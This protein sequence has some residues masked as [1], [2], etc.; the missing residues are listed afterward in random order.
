MSALHWP[1]IRGR[2]RAD[3]GPLL[4]VAV[5]VLLI[6]TL[7]A[8]V[9]PL[10]RSTAD[11][12]AREAI[13]RAGSDAAVQVQ[14]EWEP[15]YGPNGGRVRYPSL[16]EDVDDFRT[17]AEGQ[18]D[19]ELRT[20][21]K[22]PITA[23]SS[24]T[25]QVTDGSVQRH[26]QADY[27]RDEHGGP[28]VTWVSGHAPGATAAGNIE[29]PLNGPKWQVQ[30]GLSEANAA[31]LKLRPGDPVPVQ[32]DLRTKYNV[33][34]S[35]IFRVDDPN[36]PAWLVAPWL[37]RPAA[38]LDG[39][40]STR[41]GGLLTAD[42]LPDGRL[43]FLED[44]FRRTV[45]FA[46]D[47]DK[48][49]WQSA[50]ELAATVAALKS[51]SASSGERDSSL[52][53][54]T[55]LDGVLRDVRAQVD[56]A[57]A[58]A[59]VLLIA[60]LAGAVLVL[61][62]AADLLARRRSAAL[63]T[64][65]QRGAGLPTLFAELLLESL[66]TALPA[67]ALGLAAAYLLA[68]G[69]ALP[70][71]A[72][73]VV[74]A[75]LAGPAFGVLAAARATRDRRVPAN[76]SARRW[77]ERTVQLRRASVDL[78][79]LAAA[80]GAIV[81]LRQRGVADTALPAGAPTLGVVAGALLL[82]RLMPAGTGLVLRQTLRSRSPLAVFGAARAAATSTRALPLL[83]LTT[84]VALAGFAVTLEAT[85]ARGM[86]DGAWQ[87]VGAD[88]RLDAGPD[89]SDKIPEI[90]AQVA[91]APGVTRAVPA[92]VIDGVRVIADG[93]SLTPS[94]VIVDA[95]QFRRLLAA[96]PLPDAPG[97]NGLT[98]P[99]ALVRAGDGSLHPGQTLQLRLPN[100]KVVL[101]NS[102][103]STVYPLTAV[104]TA[105]IV[106]SATDV[107]VV[108]ASAGLP[109]HPDTIWATGPGAAAAVKML[110]LGGHVEVRSE[111]LSD[112]RSLPLNAGL[113]AL[114]WAAAATLLLLGLLSFALAAAA[115]A[116]SR[117]ETL[118][119]LRTLGLRP[120]DAHRVAAAE[121]QPP[122]LV[123]AVCG[124]LLA[125][126]L[127][128][129]TFAPLALRTLTGQLS[130]PAITLPWWLPVVTTALLLATLAVVVA[131]ESTVRRRLRLSDVLRVGGP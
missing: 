67:A 49:T 1:S 72:P 116:P 63:T 93:N 73:V 88:A 39:S 87:S 90:A 54:D 48:I 74:C 128:K 82:V 108:D 124:P 21:L 101:G 41:L 19:P 33:L 97:L 10:L 92:Q 125:L 103:D 109:Y 29:I 18:L 94:L 68:G 106:G 23:V 27:V 126:L 14:A 3:L 86:A 75:V 43:A 47:P 24:V 57:Q 122:A 62:L 96:T 100:D 81:S 32:D 2:A 8:A 35:G 36:D 107:I 66:V 112:R 118:A 56:A 51:T 42:S 31:A 55:R 34:V 9:P 78:A 110:G 44:Q 20:A 16:S 6:T 85:T 59:S 119:R 50:Q 12:A 65:R 61:L 45:W 64:A 76:R 13:R 58:Q 15:D 130:D 117:W 4:L 129:L 28:A 120:R 11:K 131:A 98:G 38:D 127:I 95:A 113:A 26:F 17:R 84:A 123:A 77:Q 79:V 114:D 70:W 71:A 5:V 99:R 69:A 89:S 104:G 91:A 7:A 52:K 46:A 25:L 102:A 60:V 83:V 53:W 37:V 115:S 80:A 111:V 105:P 22:A 30:V 121:L 40:G